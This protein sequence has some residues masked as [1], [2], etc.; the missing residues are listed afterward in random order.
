LLPNKIQETVFKNLFPV[1]IDG[2]EQKITSDGN[3]VNAGNFDANGFNFN[4]WWNDNRNDNIGPSSSR[5]SILQKL[6]IKQWII[7]HCFICS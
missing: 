3:R 1:F 4:N 6:K 5:N 2:S 7:L